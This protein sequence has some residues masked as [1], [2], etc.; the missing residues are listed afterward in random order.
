MMDDWKNKASRF[1]KG[2]APTAEYDLT[3]D[4]NRGQMCP[5]APT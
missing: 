3:L 1:N 5:V 4:S 2:F